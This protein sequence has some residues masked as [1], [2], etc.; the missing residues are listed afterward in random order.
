MTTAIPNCPK[1]IFRWSCT[2]YIYNPY[3]E[4]WICPRTSP[5]RVTTDNKT[6]LVRDIPTGTADTETEEKEK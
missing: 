2:G 6:T 5:M 4:A 3:V 1:C